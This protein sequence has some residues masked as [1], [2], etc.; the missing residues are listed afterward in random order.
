MECQKKLQLRQDDEACTK[1]RE[2]ANTYRGVHAHYLSFLQ[3]KAKYDWLKMGDENTSL[4]HRA[5]R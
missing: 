2:A 3:Q 1:E 5:I 4:F